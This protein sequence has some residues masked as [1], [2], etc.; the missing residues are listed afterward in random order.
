VN[1]EE[2]Q[3]KEACFDETKVQ[4]EEW[5]SEDQCDEILPSLEHLHTRDKAN[6]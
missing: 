6:H 2:A 5:D 1:P 4:I 3:E